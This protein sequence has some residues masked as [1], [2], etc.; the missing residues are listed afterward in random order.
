MYVI[1]LAIMTHGNTTSMDLPLEKQREF[2]NA[3]LFSLCG[4]FVP[5]FGSHR[6]NHTILQDLN[7][8]FRQS[9][10]NP[11]QTFQKHIKSK[12]SQELVS[13]RQQFQSE[14][15]MNGYA[16]KSCKLFDNIT[17]DKHVGPIYENSNAIKRMYSSIVSPDGIFVISVYKDDLLIYPNSNLN[18]I[19]RYFTPLMERNNLNLLKIHDFQLFGELFGKNLPDMQQ[20]HRELPEEFN[21]EELNSLDITLSNVNPNQVETIRLGFL[22]Q[23]INQLCENQC[24]INIIDFSCFTPSETTTG[25]KPYLVEDDIETGTRRQ[26]FGG[27]TDGKWKSRK[28]RK[29]IL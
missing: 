22:L 8:T 1:T 18:N 28:F 14:C 3:R 27:R 13:H 12:Y 16:S 19:R 4:D 10:A 9:N 21:K 7:Q 2:E 20:F 24:K 29:S 11:M 5:A 25:E 26:T 17:V 15:E 23:L 6:F